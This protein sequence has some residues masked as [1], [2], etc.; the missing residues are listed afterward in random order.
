[1]VKRQAKELHGALS[2]YVTQCNV[3]NTVGNVTSIAGT[4]LMFTPAF[5]V[6]I[7]M[8]IFGCSTSVG[9]QVAKDKFESYYKQQIEKILQDDKRESQKV[10][11]LIEHT[12]EIL[13]NSIQ[14]ACQFLIKGG[15]NVGGCGLQAL[16]AFQ[17]AGNVA[18]FAG[19]GIQV[20]K[21]FQVASIVQEGAQLA[22]IVQK[23]AQV[24]N[25]AQGGVQ[26]AN[27][28]QG[29]VQ[30]GNVVLR[31]GTSLSNLG[32]LSSLT[33]A[34][35][36][37]SLSVI[38]TGQAVQNVGRVTFLSSSTVN[39]GATG[40]KLAG[41][42]AS[43]VIPV[44]GVV[45][46]V[47]DI[48]FTWGS[49]NQTIDQIQK[50]E[51]IKDIEIKGVEEK[52]KV[53]EAAKDE[54]YSTCSFAENGLIDYDDQ[55][56]SSDSFYE[57]SDLEG[58]Y[59]DEE[60]NL[61]LQLSEDEEEIKFS[62]IPNN[63]QIQTV[64]GVRTKE[65]IKNNSDGFIDSKQ[66]R[67]IRKKN[68][69]E[70]IS[71]VVLIRAAAKPCTNFRSKHLASNYKSARH[72]SVEALKAGQDINTV[73][74]CPR[75]QESTQNL[76]Q[77]Q[78]N[79]KK[80]FET[81]YKPQDKEKKLDKT[82]TKICTKEQKVYE[83]EIFEFK[84]NQHKQVESRMYITNAFVDLIDT[85]EVYHFAN[86]EQYTREMGQVNGELLEV[87]RLDSYQSLGY[88][89]KEIKKLKKNKTI[90]KKNR[91]KQ[92]EILKEDIDWKRQTNRVVR[93][94]INEI[95]RKRRLYE[96]RREKE[97]REI[98]KQQER[99]KEGHQV[100]REE[101]SQ[102]EREEKANQQARKEYE[103][104]QEKKRKEQEEI[105]FYENLLRD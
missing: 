99:E 49:I 16:N 76:N 22:N 32:K 46:S 45:F 74:V 100:R 9:S 53:W 29:G 25:V 62:E 30:V 39:V 98:K 81:E 40:G 105:D 36:L 65:Q 48:A 96:I 93:N 75:E 102:Q 18:V 33:Q 73:I 57:E 10:E 85:F 97:I 82:K 80:Y 68:N 19:K 87:F 71:C 15:L 67:F 5:A 52:L 60:V 38:S 43:K 28:I 24:A 94:H 79:A 61:K 21:G 83:V 4:A 12:Q 44:M 26:A 34:T 23:G 72:K 50:L 13:S 2:D 104:R 77:N 14:K 86:R 55:S 64:C 11:E 66:M 54:I 7:G 31:G 88:L 90:D 69:P 70:Q 41:I 27:A 103:R 63:A 1:M 58:E 42:S 17:K 78:Q 51:N 47:A 92:I 20:G 3:S 89:R 37:S 6:G 95:R 84:L 91:E 59:S 8:V 56:E 101:E 35:R